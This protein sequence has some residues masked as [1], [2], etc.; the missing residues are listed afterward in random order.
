MKQ[1]SQRLSKLTESQT[2]SM[3]K[4]VRELKA[5]GKDIIGLTLGEPD[6]DT[7]QHICEAAIQA[8]RDGF[9]HYPPVAGIVELREA[10]AN[11]FRTENGIQWQAQ[12]IV[13]STGAKQSVVN[14]IM[15]LVDPGDRVVVPAPFWVSYVEMLKMAEAEIE[16]VNTTTESGFRMSAAQ[17][18]AALAKGARMLILN[19][20]NN[21]CGSMYNQQEIESFVAVLEKYPDV[22]VLSDE[23]YEHISYDV[24]H[25]SIGSYASIADR[26][27]TVNGF[28]KGFAMTGWRLG[29][30]GAAKWIADL[31]DKYQGQITSGTSTISQKAGV[32]A[33]TSG[34][35][36]T[37]EMT[38]EFKARRDF[39]YELLNAIPGVKCPLPPGAFYFYPDLS[40]FFGKTSPGGRKIEDIDDLTDYLLMEGLI[41]VIPGS[42]FGTQDHVRISY[43]YSREALRIAADRLKTSLLALR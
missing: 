40:A 35:E 19:S 4:K 3:T 20:P 29:Y 22:L 41:A 26:V 24:K 16:V 31:C 7:P 43:A 38:A 23:I 39:M 9:T 8:I 18:D 36:K 30:I 15:A 21:P 42:A 12:N 17:L 10:A 6:F 2:L 5:Q 37:R 1:G 33:L 32:V 28:S 14:A 13:V 11:K 27:I 25:V 34:L